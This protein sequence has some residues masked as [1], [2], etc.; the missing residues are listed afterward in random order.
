MWKVT[1]FAVRTCIVVVVVTHDYNMASYFLVARNLN[2]SSAAMCSD[3]AGSLF[4]GLGDLSELSD[5]Y[6]IPHFYHFPHY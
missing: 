1:A 5:R 6:Y 3:V 2:G 4:S